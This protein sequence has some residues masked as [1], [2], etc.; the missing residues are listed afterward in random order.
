M[1]IY[2]RRLNHL[3]HI[4]IDFRKFYLLH[5]ITISMKC[6]IILDTLHI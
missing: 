6:L 4:Y 3:F 1:I 5:L 2:S